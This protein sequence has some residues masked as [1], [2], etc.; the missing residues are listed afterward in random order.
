M[1]NYYCVIIII[2]FY[3]YH[4]SFRHI[5]Y[6]MPELLYFS[7]IGIGFRRKSLLFQP[8]MTPSFYRFI[9]DRED[10]YCADHT[11]QSKQGTKH[12]DGKQDP[13]TFESNRFSDDLRTDDIAVHLL[14]DDDEY[15]EDHSLKRRSQAAHSESPRCMAQKTG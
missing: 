14:N 2:I 8:A 13:E 12:Q 11:K 5:C 6:N 9:Q 4:T 7:K 15:K 10:R 1:A 3:L